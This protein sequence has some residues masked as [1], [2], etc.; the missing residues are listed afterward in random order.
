VG[1][2]DLAAGQVLEVNDGQVKVD[3][4]HPM[5]GKNLRFEVQM[6]VVIERCG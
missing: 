3:F 5:I 2:D 4:N 6:L 1:T